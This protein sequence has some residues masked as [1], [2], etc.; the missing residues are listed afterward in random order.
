MGASDGYFPRGES[1]LRQVHEERIVGLLYGQRALMIGGVDPIV[2][3]GT[4]EASNGAATP[5]DRLVRTAK[6]FETTFLGSRE[7]ADVVLDRVH[8]LHSRV[9]GELSKAAGPVPAG[10]SY[11]ALDPTQMLWT[12]GCIADSSQVIYEAL[13]RRLDSEELEGLWSDYL[14]WGGLWG[15]PTSEMPGSYR[16][17]RD[18]F[19]GRLEG[20]E[21]FLTRESREIGR[22]V[23]LELP[24]PPHLRP[25]LQ[26]SY[27]LVAGLLPPRVRRMYGLRW[28]PL[29]AA[30]FSAAAR[31]HRTAHPLVPAPLRRGSCAANYELIARSERRYGGAQSKRSAAAA[32]ARAI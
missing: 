30:A 20:N 25:G 3:S 5:F 28:T 15:L 6:I 14:R 18:W 13:V 7:E 4:F 29:H 32:A 17:F 16:E 26:V 24:G 12:L 19:D 2:S 11:D 22:I 27:L 31:A 8:R 9:K 1:V 21:L 23:A 10:T